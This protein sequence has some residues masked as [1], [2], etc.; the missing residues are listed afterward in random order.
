MTTDKSTLPTAT[1]PTDALDNMDKK[2]YEQRSTTMK[3]NQ[4]Q[5]LVSSEATTMIYTYDTGRAYA[6]ATQNKSSGGKTGIT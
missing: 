4:Y 1:R 2:Y 5:Q 3:S 6:R